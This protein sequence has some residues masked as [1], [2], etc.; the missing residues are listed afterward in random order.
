MGV[1]INDETV[2]I[3]G[4]AEEDQTL[5]LDISGISSMSEEASLKV[6]WQSLREDG[7]WDVIVEGSDLTLILDQEHVGKVIRAVA[8]YKDSFG[9]VRS[10]ATEVTDTVANINDLPTGSPVIKGD[11]LVGNHLSYDLS[12][13]DD[14]DGL[15]DPQ[16]QWEYTD[17][18]QVWFEVD[19]EDPSS[20]Y[21][22]NSLLG[23]QVRLATTYTDGWGHTEKVYSVVT[24]P[25]YGHSNKTIFFAEEDDPE[26]YTIKINEDL[27]N[28]N[29]FE[30]DFYFTYDP[31][32]KD[33]DFAGNDVIAD[34]C[35]LPTQPSGDPLLIKIKDTYIDFEC[36]DWV[37]SEGISMMGYTDQQDTYELTAGEYNAH[38]EIKTIDAQQN[39]MATMSK[40]QANNWQMDIIAND[41]GSPG[42]I[43]FIN[44]D[45][46]KTT[47]QDQAADTFLTLM[48]IRP[49]LGMMYRLMVLRLTIDCNLDGNGLEDIVVTGNDRIHAYYSLG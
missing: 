42:I 39:V 26:T 48:S 36:S 1:Y 19:V 20:L 8:T 41:L 33:S 15:G 46:T 13:L 12:S 29:S 45:G 22:D 35:I 21:L 5:E 25:V 18:G 14:E 11:M 9:V 17:N 28:A 40:V 47:F 31:S 30:L 7:L 6:S 24:D 4:T 32:I 34:I 43:R 10:L 2:S 38:I 23:K 27:S 49:G 37:A 3:T 44:E 16:A